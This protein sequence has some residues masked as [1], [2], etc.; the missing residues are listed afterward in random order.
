MIFLGGIHGVGKGYFSK[1]LEKELEIKAF[2]SSELIKN[3]NKLDKRVKDIKGNQSKLLIQVDRLKEMYNTFILDGHFCLIDDKGNFSEIPKDTFVGLNPQIMVLME[4]DP[5][6]IVERRKRRDGVEL[7][8]DK[9]SD[10]MRYERDYA[11]EISELLEKKLIICNSSEEHE[12]TI[13][14]I[15]GELQNEW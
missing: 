4:E 2:S 7:P 1:I 13:K 12:Y 11:L 15:K 3:Q 6:T 8:I 14:R 9:M 10:F 5:V